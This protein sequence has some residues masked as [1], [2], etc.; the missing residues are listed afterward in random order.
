MSFWGAAVITNFLRVMPRVGERL[1]FWV[2][3][4]YLVGEG[5]LKCF[6]FLHFFLGLFLSVLILNHLLILH[7]FG[8]SSLLFVGRNALKVVF[9]PKFLAK[10]GILVLGVGVIFGADFY[11][12]LEE[13]NFLAVDLVSSPL[14]IKPE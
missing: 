1:V 8:S 9:F 10:D 12:F 4:G 11:I 6:L 3:G 2:W 13:E 14:H 7:F 5:T